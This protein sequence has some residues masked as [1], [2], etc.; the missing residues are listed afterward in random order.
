MK[1]T[2]TPTT[3]AGVAW[4]IHRV[5]GARVADWAI[6][7]VQGAPFSIVLHH[8]RP[9]TDSNGQPMRFYRDIDAQRFIDESSSR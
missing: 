1:E 2:I 4:A 9:M 6:H 8:D 7:R 5:Q 3:V